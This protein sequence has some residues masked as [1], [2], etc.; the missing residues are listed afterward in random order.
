MDEFRTRINRLEE[1]LHQAIRQSNDVEQR[2]C[3]VEEN[4]EK[5]NQSM[6]TIARFIDVSSLFL[7]SSANERHHWFE[8]SNSDRFISRLEWYLQRTLIDGNEKQL[9]I[10][11]LFSL[12]SSLAIE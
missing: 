5:L 10:Q 11:T 6:Q 8:T 2:A 1:R 7:I 12:Q 4:F 3:F 9:Y